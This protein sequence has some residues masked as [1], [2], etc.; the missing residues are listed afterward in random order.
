MGGSWFWWYMSRPFIGMAMALIFHVVLRGGFLVNTAADGTV[1]NPFSVV[2][3]GALVGMFADKA[4][5]KLGEIFETLL[6][7]DD[8]RT[9]EPAAPSIS[10]LEPPK[11]SAGENSQSITIKGKRLG[12]VMLVQLNSIRV[13]PYFVSDHEVHFTLRKKDLKIPKVLN[14]SVIDPQAGASVS[15]KLPIVAST[16]GGAEPPSPG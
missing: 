4:A 13:K 10:R 15:A 2:A 14:I 16:N 7:S 11:V 12:K 8:P 3:L 6:K 1:A 9:D 5:V